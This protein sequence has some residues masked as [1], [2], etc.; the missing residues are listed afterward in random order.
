M[1]FDTTQKL[2]EFLIRDTKTTERD[3]VL[4]IYTTLS[5]QITLF[6]AL[7]FDERVSEKNNQ[8]RDMLFT[9]EISKWV[10]NYAGSFI[11][12]EHS[13]YN[14]D[15]IEVSV[16]ATNSVALIQCY[17]LCIENMDILPDAGIGALDYSKI[18]GYIA[19]INTAL[20]N[21]LQ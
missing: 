4:F 19:N 1:H 6:E 11:A 7:L 13:F 9:S 16:R 14:N 17:E 2:T 10:S 21:L 15:D 5:Y 18:P 20:D 3:W 8:D 12:D